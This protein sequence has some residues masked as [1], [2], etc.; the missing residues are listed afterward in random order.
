MLIYLTDSSQIRIAH[1]AEGYPIG[2]YLHESPEKPASIRLTFEFEGAVALK[3]EIDNFLHQRRSLLQAASKEAKMDDE[4]NLDE[5]IA[6]LSRTDEALDTARYK[7]RNILPSSVHTV[8]E[9][10]NGL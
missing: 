2:V 4:Q 5:R 7:G 3:S 10:T 9:V 1:D 8:G 6:E